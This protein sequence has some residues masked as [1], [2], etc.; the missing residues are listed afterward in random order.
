[1]DRPPRGQR[2]SGSSAGRAESRTGEVTFTKQLG[3]RC[4]MAPAGTAPVAM[5]ARAWGGD[6]YANAPP[7][8][9][10]LSFKRHI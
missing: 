7:H 4:R 8:S 3:R 1:M 2:G 9:S 5:P 10:L 6:A